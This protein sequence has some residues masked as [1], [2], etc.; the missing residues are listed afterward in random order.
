MDSLSHFMEDDQAAINI[1]HEAEPEEL[2]LMCDAIPNADDAE[3]PADTTADILE[4]E[5][6]IGASDGLAIAHSALL[7]IDIVADTAPITGSAPLDEVA[8]DT[9]FSS[10]TSGTA[11]DRPSTSEIPSGFVI[12]GGWLYRTIIS[13][14]GSPS[15][16]LISGAMR[17]IATVKHEDD[18][19][20]GRELEFTTRLGTTRTNLTWDRDLHKAA[21]ELLAP[22]ADKG[23]HIE[24]GNSERSALKA[25]LNDCTS[26][27][28]KTFVTRTGWTKDRSAFV[29]G[30][31]VLG[32][33]TVLIDPHLGHNGID[34]RGSLT[35]WRDGL[36]SKCSGNPL[37]LFALCFG[38][39]GPAAGILRQS[40][41]GIH[42]HGPSS[43]GKTTVATMLASIWG[44]SDSFVHSWNS[45]ANALEM[46]LSM[47]N[48]TLL[49]LDEIS[50]CRPEEVERVAYMAANGHGRSRSRANNTLSPT[51]EWRTPLFST[52][53]H[54]LVAHMASGNRRPNI[55]QEVRLISIPVVDFDGGNRLFRNLHG[56]L[57]GAAFSDGLRDC[58][59][60]NFGHAGR[61]FVSRLVGDPQDSEE[62][63]KEFRRR[64][65]AHKD[66]GLSG[67]KAR[68]FDF[69]ATVAASGMLASVLGLLPQTQDEILEGVMSTFSVWRESMQTS[70]EEGTLLHRL[71]EFLAQ[72]G[73][74][75]FAHD[76]NDNAYR[77]ASYYGFK[78][79]NTYWISSDIFRRMV[80][81]GSSPNLAYESLVEKRVLIPHGEGDTT[82]RKR[83]P[84]FGDMQVR[85][86]K[87]DADALNT[88][89]M[90][91]TE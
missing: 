45:T 20:V 66:A 21:S 9:L 30:K 4:T 38:F 64:T 70:P 1:A 50:Q 57:N 26:D 49:L 8:P 42:F 17:C 33:D 39:T 11:P 71:H 27:T 81:D 91:M 79:S 7:P 77:H 60:Q 32:A 53:E 65:L 78:E 48:D 16:Q 6:D 51:R 82:W 75:R 58:A 74:S 35:T 40:A 69:F 2:G 90:G 46:R 55:G 12:E 52:G 10:G 54:S 25:Y 84:C 28:I 3:A 13:K 24:T 89:V 36:A 18:D 59:T 83:H 34:T 56:F 61:S 72:N 87:I 43:S 62:R 37:M 85:C 68:V 29:L 88:L 22:L 15:L 14:N 31:E 86:L 44:D 23:F 67:A 47:S 41:L 80:L 19:A 73:S 76:G 5:T 63:L